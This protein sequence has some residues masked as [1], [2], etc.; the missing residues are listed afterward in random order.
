MQLLRI[1]RFTSKQSLIE[2]AKQDGV[3]TEKTVGMERSIFHIKNLLG[4]SG[5]FK[6][7][8]KLIKELYTLNYLENGELTVNR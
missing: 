2:K 1:Q 8:S 7:L 6:T 4:Q 3:K 5:F